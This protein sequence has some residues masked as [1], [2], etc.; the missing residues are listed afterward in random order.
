MDDVVRLGIAAYLSHW[1]TYLYDDGAVL[2]VVGHLN[3]AQA[4]AWDDLQVK[5]GQQTTGI[6]QRWQREGGEAIGSE[7]AAAPEAGVG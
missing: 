1:R 5:Y 4:L 3:G 6:G 7:A 2:P